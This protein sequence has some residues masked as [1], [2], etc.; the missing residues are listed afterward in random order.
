MGVT[1]ALVVDALA[2][3]PEVRDHPYGTANFSIWPIRSSWDGALL[4][5]RSAPAGRTGTWWED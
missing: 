2:S 4:G 3:E 1:L 5:W